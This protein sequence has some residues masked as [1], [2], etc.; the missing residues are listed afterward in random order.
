MTTFIVGASNYTLYIVWK[1]NLNKD[2]SLVIVVNVSFSFS[3]P[4]SH[5]NKAH[6]VLILFSIETLFLTA[7]NF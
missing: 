5:N 2:S 3:S 6:K 7:P 4:F 1:R